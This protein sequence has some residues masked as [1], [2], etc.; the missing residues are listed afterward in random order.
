[1]TTFDIGLRVPLPNVQLFDVKVVDIFGS[2]I[3]L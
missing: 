1:M 2:M 3:S